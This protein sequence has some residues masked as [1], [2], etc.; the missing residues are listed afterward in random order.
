M[1]RFS[2]ET[3]RIPAR[4]AAREPARP[5]ASAPGV[6][7]QRARPR[8]LVAAGLRALAV[9]GSRR[10]EEQRRLLRTLLGDEERADEARHVAEMR[11]RAGRARRERALRDG[12]REPLPAQQEIEAQGG[13]EGV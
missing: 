1:R 13:P 9:Q 3:A 8:R 7:A 10:L 11:V 2:S 4:A 12:A 5:G 6:R